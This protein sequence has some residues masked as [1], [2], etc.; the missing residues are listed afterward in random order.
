MVTVLPLKKMSRQ[1]KLR[2]LEEIW[3]DLSADADVESPHWHADELRHAELLVKS[4]KA[5]FADW[6]Q[7]KQ[8]IRRKIA[9]RP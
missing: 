3:T 6:R 9:K 8:R 1:A 5:G 7:A 4:G 2:A